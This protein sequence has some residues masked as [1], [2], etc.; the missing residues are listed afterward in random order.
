MQRD[1]VLR[2]AELSGGP[3]LP[4][5]PRPGAAPGPPHLLEHTPAVCGP[6]ALLVM[7]FVRCTTCFTT[8]H[9]SQFEMLKSVEISSCQC[10]KT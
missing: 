3:L 5:H 6:G 4:A 8:Y 10:N 1:D 7:L 2:C 9:F